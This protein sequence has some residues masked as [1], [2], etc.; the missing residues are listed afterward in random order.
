VGSLF[1]SALLAAQE[2]Y[3]SGARIE[4]AKIAAMQK[5]PLVAPSNSPAK[6]DAGMAEKKSSTSVKM[7]VHDRT[8]RD[9]VSTLRQMNLRIPLNGFNPEKMKGSFYEKRGDQLHGAVDM[10]AP[11]NTP[12]YAVCDGQIAKLFLS[13]LGGL[14]IYQFDPDRKFVF[15]YAHLQR[16][17]DNLV[18]GQRVKRGQLIGYVGTSGN[19]PPNTP[20]LHFSIGILG[21]DK[22]WWKAAAI[23]PYEVF[24]N[25][26]RPSAKPT[27]ISQVRIEV[28]W[29]EQ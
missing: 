11:R 29:K 23:D 15:Y 8:W 22:S 1:G 25:P 28:A 16:Y 17:A 21:S 27:P 18:E 14:T 13:R 10:L 5:A 3:D 12:I 20:H 4:S 19:A 6:S 2:T 9:A 24:S 26:E 7:K